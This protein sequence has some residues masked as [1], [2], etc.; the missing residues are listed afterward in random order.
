[1]VLAASGRE[2]PPTQ[3]TKTKHTPTAPGTLQSGHGGGN[4]THAPLTAAGAGGGKGKGKGKGEGKG[5]GKGQDPE[6]GNTDSE[7]EGGKVKKKTTA[8]YKGSELTAVPEGERCCLR[9]LFV[10]TDGSNVSLCASYN[11]GKQCPFGPHL[12]KVTPAMAKTKLFARLKAERGPPNVPPGGP[13]PPNKL[14]AAG[15]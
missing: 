2:Q 12:L 3:P 13:A 8:E 5:K 4:A 14:N 1:M 10:K 7:G 15:T 9:Y 11:K 6:S